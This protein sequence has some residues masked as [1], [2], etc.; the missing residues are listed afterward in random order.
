MILQCPVNTLGYGYSGYNIAKQLMKSLKD[1]KL[2][3]YPIGNSD[4][5]LLYELSDRLWKNLDVRG[6]GPNVKI[7]HQNQLHEFVGK[8][9]RIGFPIFELDRFTDEEKRSMRHCDRLFVCSH[10]AKN[11]VENEMPEMRASVVPLG[12]NRDIF[13]EHNNCSRPQ[14]VFFNCGKWEIRKGHDLLIKAFNSAFSQKDNV[15]LWMMCENPFIGEEG[16]SNWRNHYNRSSLGNKIR[17]IP[18]QGTHRDVYNIIRQVDCGVF[19]ARSEGWNLELLECLSCGKT[20]IATDYSGHS[21]FLNSRNSLRL[22]VENLI[23]ARDDIWFFDQGHWAEPNFD[24]LVTHM[25]HVHQ[26]KQDGE[27]HLN[28]EGVE[29]ARRFSWA[30]SAQ[31]ILSEIKYA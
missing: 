18:R 5:S 21:E 9:E 20:V 24:Q 25:K 16:N 15:E 11:I 8:E 26:T 7:F 1:E 19:P 27:L 29:T 10:W 17:F 2:T 22:D 6:Q 31:T 28:L 13:N 23:S 3:I 4:P 12:V 30:N 14:T